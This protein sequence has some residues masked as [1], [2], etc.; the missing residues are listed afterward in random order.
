MTTPCPGSRLTSEEVHVWWIDLL[1]APDN[2]AVLSPEERARASRFRQ[3]RDRIRWSRAHLAVRHILGRYLDLSPQDV[4]FTPDAMPESPPSPSPIAMGEGARGVRAPTA[5]PTLRTE[6]RLRFNLAHAADRAVLAV[7]WEREV[8]ID[9]EPI[10][11]ALDPRLLL[12]IA[13]GPAEMDRIEAMPPPA[14]AA[15]FLTLWTA[16]E[17]YLKAIGLGLFR[18][19]RALH[20]EFVPGGRAVVH[21]A[22]DPAA[23]ARWDVRLLDAGP[24][25]SAALAAAGAGYNMRPFAWPIPPDAPT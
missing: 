14:R 13:C 20:V 22:H 1:V 23:A 21:D 19:P 4:R 7:G 3:R 12:P 18:D 25:W 24:G 15:A 5:K 2:D 8:G 11:A 9:L 17:A 16:K 6:P 10:D